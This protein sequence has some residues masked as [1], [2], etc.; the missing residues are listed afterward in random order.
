M[1]RFEALVASRKPDGTF[2]RE[3]R[4]QDT[5]DLPSGDLLV[6]VS[7]S[8]LNYK[9]AL[10]AVGRH[11]VARG[12]PLTPGI[13]AGGVV[14]ESSVGDFAP[15]DSVIACGRE[16]G[17][18]VPGGFGQYIRIPASWALRPPSGLT[19]R[20]CMIIGTAGFTAALCLRDLQQHGVSPGAEVLVT[21]ASGGVGCLAVALLSKLGYRV[22]AGTGKTDKRDFLTSLGAGEVIARADLDDGSG[23]ALLSERW[24]GVVDTVGGN[25]LSTAIRSTAYGG[26]V[27]ACGNVSSPDL[28]LT[29]FP[30][31][32]RGVRLLGIDSA[33]C[34]AETRK[35]VWARLGAQWRPAQL[36]AIAEE[37]SLH[38]LDG[39]ID[40]ILHGRVS[41]RV[42]VNLQAP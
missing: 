8:S 16:L 37:C 35:E 3:L 32:L 24:A 1:S 20:E 29:V 25:I 13:D 31:I 9:D 36:E 15:G 12:Y 39:R 19:L 42:I 38:G 18:S 6:R 23:K 40:D 7:Y 21:G 17:I 26:S 4:Q 22:A 30:F 2:V 11:G 27:A 34:P 28:P 5:A 41:G 14:V 10:A 33:K